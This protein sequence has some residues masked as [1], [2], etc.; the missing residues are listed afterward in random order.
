MATVLMP[1]AQAGFDPTEAGV[2]FVRLR[3][4]G[5][6]V[7]VAT[8]TG[9]KAAADQRMLDGQGLG[10]FKYL[11][12]ADHRGRAAYAAMADSAEFSQPLSYGQLTADY[13]AL[14]LPGGHDK[15]R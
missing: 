6:R 11:M 13:D 4:A 14:L 3:A 12:R 15:P 9:R 5:H 2:P 1:V 8:P 7:M 10:P